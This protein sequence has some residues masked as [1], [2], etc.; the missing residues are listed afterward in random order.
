MSAAPAGAQAG[1]ARCCHRAKCF[2]LAVG[3]CGGLNQSLSHCEPPET[4]L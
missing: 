4:I 1:T 2:G 3:L